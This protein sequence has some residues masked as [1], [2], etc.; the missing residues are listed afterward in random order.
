MHRE[1]TVE[2]RG[3]V[4]SFHFFL[5]YGWVA[6]AQA[7]FAGCYFWAHASADVGVDAHLHVL[8]QFV[9][10][11]AAETGAIAKCPNAT[12]DSHASPHAKRRIA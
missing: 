8:A 6:E 4:F 10:I 7:G 11:L 5:E 12:K 9:L 1:K 3:R 2:A